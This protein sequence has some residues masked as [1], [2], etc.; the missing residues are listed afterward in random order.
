MAN[1]PPMIQIDAIDRTDLSNRDHF[2]ARLGRLGPVLGMEKLGCTL[3]ELEPG[4]KAWPYHLHY[5]AEEL[6]VILAGSGT[7]RYAGNELPIK[8]GDIIFTPPGENTAHQIVNTSNALLRYLALS[9]MDNPELCYYP[10][11]GKYAAYSFKPGSARKAFIAHED[12]AA[13]YW[14]GEQG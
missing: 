2:A 6:F 13:Q 10:D 8:A 7:I 3:V 5:G 9:T 11:S 14:D 1:K 4:K 12:S